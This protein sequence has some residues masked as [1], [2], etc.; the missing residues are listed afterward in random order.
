MSEIVEAA[1]AEE[2]QNHQQALFSVKEAEVRERNSEDGK[3][4]V[5]YQQRQSNDSGEGARESLE[6]EGIRKRLKAAIL[7]SSQ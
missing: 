4:S 6:R 1:S 3:L 7:K 5:G 2:A